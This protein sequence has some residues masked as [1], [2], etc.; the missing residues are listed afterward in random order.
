MFKINLKIAFRNLMKNKVYA[1]INIGGLAIGLTSFL[2]LL[3][4]VN[5]ESD[6]DTWNPKLKTV[7]QLREYH[8]LFTPDNKARW[9]ETAES[10]IANLVKEKIPQ[11]AQVTK[12]GRDWGENGYAVKVASGNPQMIK[13]VRDADSSFFKVFPY[14]FIQG[15]ENTAFA[16]P[17]TAVIKKEIAIQ[18]FGTDRV[19]GKQ[20]KVLVWK[21]D[22]GTVYTITGVVEEPN[23]P[24]STFFNIITHSGEREIDPQNAGSSNYCEIYALAN[25]A[26][27]TSLVNKNLSKIYVD[28]QKAHLASRGE[29]FKAYFNK[30]FLP[31]LKVVPIEDVY[32][33]PS[34]ETGWFDKI[35]PL[36]ALSVFLLLV[37]IINFVNLSTA[38][39]IQRA[40]EVGV[41]KVLGAVRPQLVKQFLF[42]SAIQTLSA[43]FICIIL[44]EM[45]LPSFNTHFEVD[46]SFWLNKD[47]SFILLQSLFIFI[48]VTLLAGFYPAWLLSSYRPVSVLKGNYE[49]GSRGFFLRNSLV[50]LQFGIA[51]TFI[52]CIGVM[53]Q[54]THFVSEKDLG[55]ERQQLVNILT[56][57]DEGDAF[58]NEIKT[59]SGVKYV[60]TTTQV[61]GN[62]FNVPHDYTFNNQKFNFNTVTVSMEALPALG[63][64]VVKGRLFDAAFKQDTVNSVVVNQAAA[65]LMGKDVVGKTFTSGKANNSFQIVGVIKD[66]NNEGFDKAVLPTVY[67]V[68]HLGGSSNTNN[69]LVK[70]DHENYQSAMM[71][72]ENLWKKYFPDYPII[73]TNLNDV[74]ERVLSST[75]KQMQV[76]MVFSFISIILSLL[77]LFALSTFMA[78]RRTKEIAIRKIMGASDLQLINRLNR[79]FLVLVIIA[80]LLS[81]PVGFVLMQKWLSGFAYRID[82][83]FWPFALATGS[84][85][86]IALLTVS[87]QARKA[88]LANP[89]DALKYE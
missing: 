11:F 22:P 2:L 50:I 12:V 89:V 83:P 16:A 27:D 37:S 62:T 7:Y 42:E 19:L 72:I 69:L 49:N 48:L 54:Q 82:F 35:K 33:N 85:V 87:I 30:G 38:Q 65:S 73:Y 64:Q 56:N 25:R 23:T 1:A 51:V 5:H 6:Y 17:A 26:L 39:A 68:T 15:N 61:M 75:K 10:R 41:K 57:Y 52:I 70:F 24:Q 66:Y 67:K 8:D 63:V 29:D 28:F 60:A 71:K 76:I 78:K 43:F 47:L 88:A 80:N 21:N 18:L 3:L 46:L 40:K 55:F 9:M 81:W 4:F 74:F 79:S 59:I 45:L 32:A 36:I 86:I 44:V 77:G 13:A 31:N 34:T 84:S 58:V 20:L 14:R 53:Q